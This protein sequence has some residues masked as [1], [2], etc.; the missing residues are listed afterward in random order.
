MLSFIHLVVL[1]VSWM[2]LMSARLL[3][4]TGRAVG[5]IMDL[6]EQYPVHLWC[7]C[8]RWTLCWLCPRRA[9]QAED[10]LLAPQKGRK[11]C[12]PEM[13]LRRHYTAHFS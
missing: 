4:G 6:R 7:L 3:G 10:W 9:W 8:P 5:L 11:C 2:F 1:G 12:G 13:E